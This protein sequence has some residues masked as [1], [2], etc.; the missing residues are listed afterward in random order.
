MFLAY[1]SRY[2]KSRLK[3]TGLVKNEVCVPVKLVCAL[4]KDIPDGQNRWRSSSH[5]FEAL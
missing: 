4:L 3:T 1:Y 2:M 5:F